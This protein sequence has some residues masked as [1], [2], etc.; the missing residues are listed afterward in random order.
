MASVVKRIFA[1]RGSLCVNV[2]GLR[3]WL[4]ILSFR[5]ADDPGQGGGCHIRQIKHQLV[6]I[7]GLEGE[8]KA[9]EA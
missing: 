1:R 7:A 4:A 3:N 2:A 5:D 9:C 8:W 6:E